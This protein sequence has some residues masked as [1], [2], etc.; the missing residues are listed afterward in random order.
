MNLTCRAIVTSGSILI[1][2]VNGKLPCILPLLGYG[3]KGVETFA[4]VFIYLFIFILCVLKTYTS[5]HHM[6]DDQEIVSDLPELKLQA[7]VSCRVGAENE[8]KVLGKNSQC[9]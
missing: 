5:A 3:K 1:L 9:S 8:T 7:V 2:L 4:E 6:R